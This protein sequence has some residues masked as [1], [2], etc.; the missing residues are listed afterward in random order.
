[1]SHFQHDN[2]VKLIG[3]CFDLDSICIIMELMEGGDLQTYLR[4]ARPTLVSELYTQFFFIFCN[5]FLLIRANLE[6]YHCSS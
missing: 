4:H 2:I 1:M 3:V 6:P 5:L